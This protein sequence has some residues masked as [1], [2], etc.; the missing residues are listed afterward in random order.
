MNDIKIENQEEDLLEQLTQEDTGILKEPLDYHAPSKTLIIAVSMNYQLVF[1]ATEKIEYKLVSNSLF[2]FNDADKAK[3]NIFCIET[4]KRGISSGNIDIELFDDI[5]SI[6]KGQICADDDVI[7]LAAAY[8]LLSYLYPIFRAVPY[9]YFNGPAASGKSTFARLI[10]MLAFNGT[11][12]VGPTL[13]AARDASHYSRG[14]VSFDDCEFLSHNDKNTQAYRSGLCS[15]SE[16]LAKTRL[17]NS[18]GEIR[19][20]YIG[21]PK[22]FNSISGLE[23]VLGT[24]SICIK[25]KQ[26]DADFICD[27]NLREDSDEVKKIRARGMLFA[28]KNHRKIS[29]NFERIHRIS[30]REHE[31]NNS[32]VAIV[33]FFD[34]DLSTKSTRR[35]KIE[36]AFE[37]NKEAKKEKNGFD[38]L[39]IKALWD[40]WE[41]IGF[42]SYFTVLNSQLKDEIKSMPSGDIPKNNQALQTKIGET[43][44]SLDLV[45]KESRP[46]IGKLRATQ[47]LI[48]TEI[49]NS[50]L[51]KRFPDLW[52]LSSEGRVSK[53]TLKPLKTGSE[54]T[55]LQQ[56]EPVDL[57][58]PENFLF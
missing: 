27:R 7:H 40:L 24:R 56:K 35:K 1:E 13:A 47:Y 26:A 58:V 16:C 48:A 5:I 46:R 52:M 10:S 18:N 41:E 9:L 14:L 4:L 51:K 22:L 32:L 29:E 12:L 3:V 57:E 50:I 49:L 34:Q 36:S 23:D 55:P 31:L 33:M 21:G 43:L 39:L 25:T 54:G 6:L 45:K 28:L 37:K 38:N 44:Q 8:I 15:G 53:K 42:S 17:A 30:S 19:E 11:H 20:Y 2:K